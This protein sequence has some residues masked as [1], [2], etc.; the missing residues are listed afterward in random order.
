MTTVLWWVTLLFYDRARPDN[1]ASNPLLAFD[2]KPVADALLSVQSLLAI[3]ALVGVVVALR[4]RWM[5]SSR[6]QR[7]V[8]VPVYAAAVVL[9]ALLSL[10]LV[11]DVTP[12][13]NSVERVID[14]AGLVSLMMVPFA[15]LGGL[16]RMRLTRRARCRSWWRACPRARTAAAG[17]ATRWPTPSA[18]R[19]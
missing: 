16:L 13:P 11:A 10:S 5:R 14:I 3:A 15:F 6:T 18:T 7:Q 12:M 8:L 9:A 4:Q 2:E 17:C 1:W 19:G